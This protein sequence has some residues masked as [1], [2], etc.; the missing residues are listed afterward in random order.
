MR[1]LMR[2]P[3]LLVPLF[4]LGVIALVSKEMDLF[5]LLRSNVL[6]GHQ[7]GGFYLLPTNQ[8]LRPWGLQS[9]IRGRP[10]DL[11]MD[12]GER[13]LAVLNSRGVELMHAPT[14][15]TYARVR[16]KTTSYTGI[17]F[18]PSDREIWASE[19][20]RSGPDGILI[21]ELSATGK[22]TAKH[23]IELP[24]HPVPT[25]IAFSADGATAYVAFSLENAVAVYDAT[26]RKLVKKIDVGV[27]PFDVLFSVK[28]S[29]L[30]VSNRGGRRPG[31]QDTIA[32]S[33]GSPVIVDPQ[34]G[35][36]ATGTVSVI[37]V[38]TGATQ[39][40]EVGSAPAGMA[41]SPDEKTLA[42]ANAHSD[43]ISLLDTETFDRTDI[44]I[45]SW[46]GG[47]IGSQPDAVSFSPGGDRLYVSCGGTNAIRV[48]LRQGEGWR[49]A[50]AVPT[51]W[52]PSA[53]AVDREGAL[54]I[55]NIKG[56][57]NTANEKGSFN[58]KEYEGSLLKIAAPSKARLAAGSREVR[59]ANS[60][61]FEPAGGVSNLSSLGIQYVFLIIKENRTYDQVFGD[62]PKGNCDPN[63]VM[64]GRNVTPNH[65]A[66]A[67]EYV[68]LDNFYD[69]SAISFDGHQWLMQGFVSDYVERGLVSAPRG[70]A[71]NM[72]DA[73]T[74]S[75]AGFFWQGAS[76]PIR[77]RIYGEF[78]LPAQ[79]DPQTQRVVDINKS[80]LL[81]WTEYWR[82]Y[83][84]GN[85][86]S[87]VGSRCGV[88]ALA[89]LMCTRYP[90]N[91]M[92][93]PDQLRADIFLE[94][95]AKRDK[96]GEMENL[97]V[98]CFTSDHTVGTRP[99]WPTPRAMVADNDLALGR[100]VEGISK[101]RFWSKSLILV[102]ED[103]AQD[104]L[105][106]VDGHRTV[107]LAIGPNIRRSRLDSNHYNQTSMIRTIQE[108]FR[109]QPRT[110]A[111]K[112]AR[113]MTSLFTPERNLAPYTH[114]PAN[115][116]L[117]ELNPP[118]DKLSGNRRH[119]AEQSLAI[120]FSDIDDAP[121]EILKRILWNDAKGYKTPYPN[122]P[123]E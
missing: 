57:G 59:V 110:R 102:V 122:L 106:H 90:V 29:C 58:S 119:A 113:P 94:E 19:A 85:W 12:S 27:A 10:V 69:S 28:R 78:S 92:N 30:F 115:I 38:R 33:A 3:K 101:S 1:S 77:V 41:L 75:P 32:S 95:L 93:I 71:W 9:M 68:L 64:Y 39:Q 72:A 84:E 8:L 5:P 107:A 47:V 98:V 21:V 100:V 7:E 55:I 103:D 120:N 79:W 11:A 44:T 116:K 26:T 2:S 73:L 52:F 4:L 31:P 48:L 62:I 37:N 43:T 42:V 53:V 15:V 35:A 80:D 83:R 118:L 109:I 70:Y 104:G 20:T 22:V 51:G 16:S 50:G 18:R 88:P 14:G 54:H 60:P 82:L 99:G 61:R 123:T 40:V 46:P 81:R 34:T 6:L 45:S 112:A 87:V 74:V 36:S 76:K 23:Q 108:I 97:N 86:K 67:E 91:S 105:D 111:L 66:L 89:P 49:T 13:V 63:L 96:G 25:G 56:V 117:D 17:A 24:G 114:R 121:H 65:H